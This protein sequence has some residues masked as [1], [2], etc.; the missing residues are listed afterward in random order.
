MLYEIYF[1]AIHILAL[2]AVCFSVGL[3]EDSFDHQNKKP[4]REGYWALVLL[5]LSVLGL[6]LL[7]NLMTSPLEDNR[8]LFLGFFITLAS[9]SLPYFSTTHNAEIPG[10]PK[11]NLIGW[12]TIALGGIGLLPVLLYL[13]GAKADSIAVI[14]H[15]ITVASALFALLGE[16]IQSDGKGRFSLTDLGKLIFTAILI[17][18]TV[19]VVNS[20][21]EDEEKRDLQ[22]KM[23][24]T[25]N[26]LD[27]ARV[28]LDVLNHQL[29]RTGKQFTTMLD[30]NGKRFLE[31][32]ASIHKD[33]DTIIV[34]VERHL[35]D[36]LSKGFRRVRT[37]IQNKIDSIRQG[38]ALDQDLKK[39]YQQSINQYYLLKKLKGEMAQGSKLASLDTFIRQEQEKQLQ[40]VLLSETMLLDIKKEVL[41]LK[42]RLNNSNNYVTRQDLDQMKGDM[43]R[44]VHRTLKSALD[45]LKKVK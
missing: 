27:S 10:W 35:E 38:L 44:D 2:V 15:S 5:G 7:V 25:V 32:L 9:F 30:T 39:V 18:F 16:T 8:G 43:I 20:Q 12:L 13:T 37:R 14:G 4:T 26:S 6:I 29:K 19:S 34:D 21:I 31:R 24:Q 42:Q 17:G 1:L 28:V 23:S 3:N 11:I 36:S 40:K 41:L 45:T 33:I 22:K